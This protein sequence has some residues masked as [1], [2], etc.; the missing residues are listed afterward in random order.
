[1]RVLKGGLA[2]KVKM[3]AATLFLV[4]L[5]VPAPARSA[6]LSEPDGFKRVRIAEVFNS[7]A[8]Q[9]LLL[10]FN[11]PLSEITAFP[12]SWQTL[13]SDTPEDVAKL[14]DVMTTSPYDVIITGDPDY[15]AE[16]ESK[17][18]IRRRVP[19]WKER[20]IL[21]GPAARKAELDGL[22]AD[23]IM[24]RISVGNELFFSFVMDGLARKYESELW[25]RADKIKAGE[26]RGYVET[27]RD[28]LNAL[29]QVAEEGGFALVGE[30][31]YVQYAVSERDEP[32]LVKM[33]D[34]DFFLV[35]Q[36]CLM[37]SYGF[38]KARA[39]GAVKYI[40]WFEG[41][42]ARKIVGDF[43]MGGMK[44]FIPITPPE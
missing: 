12:P 19:V 16:M 28:P 33:A 35:T 5:A 1:M 22:S 40:E 41:E 23:E 43:S 25:H 10:G 31:S 13:P 30:A 15:A 4:L 44:P 36:V 17:K 38:R 26:N 6:G 42:A 18:L 39:E 27:S 20:L 8:A 34:T 11:A 32:A 37:D 9:L 29:F 24:S 2:V 3:L 21:I 7:P 14:G